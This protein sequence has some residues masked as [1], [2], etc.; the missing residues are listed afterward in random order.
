VPASSPRSPERLHLIADDLTGALD[1]AAQ[2]VGVAGPISVIWRA[3]RGSETA[4]SL[5]LDSGTREAR[6]AQARATTAA[7]VGALPGA[8]DTLHFAKLDSLLRGRAG[9]QIAGWLDVL[10]FGHCIVAPAFPFQGRVTRDGVQHAR[11]PAGWAPVPADLHGD[12][13]REGLAVRRCRPGDPVPG[14]VSLWDAETDADLAA[15]AAAGRAL[16]APVL[17]CGSSGLAGA[18]AGSAR[19]P[20]DAASFALPRPIL[21]VIGTREPATL[22]QLAACA[23]L[24]FNLRDGG[25]ESAALVTRQIAEHGIALVTLALPQGLS[26]GE[27]SERIAS[28]FGA[29]LRRLD[30]P[31]TLFVS[32]GET[33]RGL[34]TVIG[35]QRLDLD[36]QLLPGIPRS[37][38]CGGLLDGVRV[39]S[40]SG[41]F[42]E[43]D[44]LRRLLV[45]IHQKGNPQ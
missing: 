30:P 24:V 42:G 8:S 12:L 11:T 27:A 3:P 13:E 26:G 33:L 39:V 6:G 29:L 22:A 17:W 32:G 40:K 44:V 25:G 9:A 38:M 41:A 15:I 16:A 14:G 36:G 2:L 28:A 45:D 5:A 43:P 37:V 1:T 19:T 4:G 18:L 34:C 23:P 31:G 7:L 35:A 20:E 21:G 10:R